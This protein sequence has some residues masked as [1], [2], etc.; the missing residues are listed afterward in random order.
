MIT[1]RGLLGSILAAGVAPAFVASGLMKGRG[2]IVPSQ[3]I[4]LHA[5]SSMGVTLS[6]MSHPFGDGVARTY[7][8]SEH[9]GPAI[10]HDDVLIYDELAGRYKINLARSMQITR[11]QY[12][13]K[14]FK[15]IT[16]IG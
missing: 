16:S 8:V 12:A 4:F 6:S 14:A 15:H 9:F 1:R 2:I 7:K 5:H 11:D 3:A 10:F 13:E